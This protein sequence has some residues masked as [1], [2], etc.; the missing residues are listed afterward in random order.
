M[1]LQS[2]RDKIDNIDGA[3][4][5][6][7][8][9]RMKIVG[10]IAEY[11]KANSLPVF[12]SD[13]EEKIV[14]RVRNNSPKGLENAS[15][16][17]FLNLMDV[18]KAIQN[19]RLFDE[20]SVPA[21]EKFIPKDKKIIACQG[22]SG[23]YSTDAAKKLFPKSETIYFEQFTDVIDAVTDGKAD[24]GLLPLQ[25]STCGVI[26]ETYDILAKSNLYINAIIRVNASHCIAAKPDSDR[27]TRVYSKQEAL[28][29]CSEYIKE[30]S[31]EALA[32]ANTAL[33]AKFVA[34][35]DEKNIAC[36]CSESCAK[37]YGLEIIKAE[38]ANASPNFT[39]FICFSKTFSE[40][41]DAD[42]ISVSLSIP[43]TKASLYR[44]LTKF[45]VS[46]LNLVKIENKAVAGSDFQVIFYLDFSGSYADP[47]VLALLDDL[48]QNLEYFKFLGSFKEIF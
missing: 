5:D 46:G 31:L 43:H 32:F 45:A 21:V 34:S 6:L 24:C 30:N 4:L 47:N 41:A 3:I 9:D 13:R 16:T 40:I 48:R 38:I 25:N 7:F 23:A 11:K 35:S 27:I 33:A 42:T 17:L 20:K 8:T 18:S 19:R 36:I 44:L 39:R 12:Q 26:T 1:D 29:Q 37:Q 10:D 15:E 28:S 22:A 14:N 2:L